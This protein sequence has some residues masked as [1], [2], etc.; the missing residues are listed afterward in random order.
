MRDLCFNETRR[1][2]RAC[3]YYI[4]SNASL[5]WSRFVLLFSLVML[6]LCCLC[7]MVALLIAE[8]FL[9]FIPKPRS[10][11]RRP[12]FRR[13]LK[14]SGMKLENKLKNRQLK[15]Q[16]VAKKQRKEQKKLRKAVKDANTRTPQ[17]LETYRKRPG[18]RPR[19]FQL[20]WVNFM[21]HDALLTFVCYL[22]GRRGGRGVSGQSAY[23]HGGGR[24]SRTDE[25][26]GSPAVLHHQRPVVMVTK[27][28]HINAA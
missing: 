12:T 21:S 26:H 2:Q 10:K 3:I 4:W 7:V 15:Q 11:K 14:T 9:L 16:N 24:G 22:R 27:V 13:L 6:Q 8:Y 19:D 20:C 1:S 28:T 18:D 25:H 23:G 5:Y 17:P